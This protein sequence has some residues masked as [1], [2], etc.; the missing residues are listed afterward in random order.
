[1]VL[2]AQDWLYVAAFAI[3]DQVA[4]AIVLATEPSNAVFELVWNTGAGFGI[5]Q[6]QNW[7]LLALG[8]VVFAIVMW[9]L[10]PSAKPREHFAYLAFA[11]GILGNSI[12][13]VLHGA[14]VDF[15]SIGS[16]PVFNLADSFITIS[17][18]YLVAKGLKESFDNWN[19]SKKR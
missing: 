14:V 3:I 18:A 13:R 8:L 2:R 9:K 11:G 1:M 4:K 10:V 15:I 7:W 6:G 17:V 5:L 12:D 19:F 16:F